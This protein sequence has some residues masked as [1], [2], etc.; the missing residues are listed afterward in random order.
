[1]AQGKYLQ[2]DLYTCGINIKRDTVAN[3]SIKF[4]EDNAFSFQYLK[5]ACGCTKILSTTEEILR[6][7][8]IKVEFNVANSGVPSTPGKHQINRVVQIFF[9]DGK[10][11]ICVGDN[12]I[13]RPTV[14]KALERF[15]I[16]G[17]VLVPEDKEETAAV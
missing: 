9:D 12:G 1:M 14:G 6:D 3:F 11:E 7:K 2:E 10:P 15:T 4:K 8:E 13:G 17:T 16:T 5:K